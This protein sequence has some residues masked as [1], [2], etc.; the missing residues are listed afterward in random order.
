VIRLVATDL[1]GTFWGPDFVAPAE[2]LAAVDAL[3]RREVVVLAAT[4]RRP[5]VT[6][7]RLREAG[8][9][10]P[11]ILI[12][13]GIGIDFRTDERFHE[14]VFGTEAA[15]QTLAVFQTR[16]LDPCMY[17][18]DPEFDMAV[19]DRP[20]TCRA[21]VDHL[22]DLARTRDLHE[23]ATTHAVY[24]FSLLGL[25]HEVLEPLARELVAASGTTVVLYPEPHYGGF[26]LIVNPEGVSKWSGI[27]AYCALYDIA[28]EEVA[29]VGDGLNDLEMLRRAGVPIGVQGGSDDVVEVAEFLIEPPEHSGWA[30]IV[31]II[32]DLA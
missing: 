13:G 12:D 23:T 8:L 6:K 30:S 32:E 2:H 5:R 31:D 29:A 11:A 24:A 10:L 7:Q 26:G 16:G 18:E 17:V 20:S 1:D 4:S 22:G 21:H 19:S 9:R 27:E 14:A 25:D 28:P 3:A 15:R